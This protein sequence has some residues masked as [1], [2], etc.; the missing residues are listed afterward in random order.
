MYCTKQSRVQTKQVLK[1]LKDFSL[2]AGT[3]QSA[4]EQG[5]LPG[6]KFTILPE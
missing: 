2:N 1:L 6:E 3:I 4:F 5:T